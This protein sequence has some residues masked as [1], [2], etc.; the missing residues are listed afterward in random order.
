[1]AFSTTY[2]QMAAEYRPQAFRW[3]CIEA[4]EEYWLRLLA[5]RRGEP[6]YYT[7]QHGAE[8][9]VPPINHFPELADYEVW[10]EGY[11][12]TGEQGA[13]TLWGKAKARNFAEAC[14]KVACANYL[15]SIQQA[16]TSPSQQY[17]I[18]RWDYDPGKLAYWGCRLYWSR[19]L[20]AKSF[21]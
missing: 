2:Q 6:N 11:A 8:R 7:N 21:G 5:E 19:E 12:A 4:F 9:T 16:E 14:H 1:M 17:A 10:M 15:K 13:A 3:A 20:A 18:G